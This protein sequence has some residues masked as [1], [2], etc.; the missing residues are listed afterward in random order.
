LKSLSGRTDA[1][2]FLFSEEAVFLLPRVMEMMEFDIEPLVLKSLRAKWRDEIE[3]A[4]ANAKRTAEDKRS[5]RE[6]YRAAGRRER[7]WRRR[8]WRGA[9]RQE[10]NPGV[11]PVMAIQRG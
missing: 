3:R 9:E 11:R 8:R 7:V 4:I 1:N 2:G 5:R 6:W 10:W